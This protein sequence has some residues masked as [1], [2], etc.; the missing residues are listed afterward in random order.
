MKRI[1]NVKVLAALVMVIA[2]VSCKAP[3]KVAQA[4]EQ[5][6]QEAT[7]VKAFRV[8][9]ERISAKVSYTGTLEA[10][11]KIAI[12]PDVGGKIARINV[13]EGDRVSKG[14]VLAEIDTEATRLQLKQ[15]EAGLAVA[16]AGFNDAKKN[17]E[18]MDRLIKENAVSEQQ[19]EQVRLA[20]DAADAQ[21]QQAQAALNIVAHALD[22]SIMKAPWSGIIASKNAEVGDVINPMMGGF[23][24]A[25]G[26]LT[27]M[28]F[29]K[30]KVVVDISG[31][32]ISRVRT[33]QPVLL[34]TP[35]FP[36]REFKG[37]VAIANLTA[38][39]STKKFLVEAVFDNPGLEL[40]PGTFCEVTFEVNSH[41]SA[42]VVPQRAVLEN[43]HVIVVENGKA[44]KRD[45]ILGIQN[46]T[47]VEVLSGIAEGEIVV[48]EGN[49]GLEA[50]SSVQIAEEVKS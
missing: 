17:K 26:V 16:R 24:A 9:R 38:D 14:Q 2:L 41:E 4:G 43:A 49:F 28:D 33:G 36:G 15:A 20:Y 34:K 11:K 46:T 30:V 21:L 40:R 35:S 5:E 7:S 19:Y 10:V 50:G 47:M 37:E 45:V 32:D 25:T 31:N 6:A 18:R 44:V 42:L 48:V 3:K 39:P 12:T 23:S 13:R 22:V 1:I 27:L 8:V 29:A